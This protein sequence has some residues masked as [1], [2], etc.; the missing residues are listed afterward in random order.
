MDKSNVGKNQNMYLKEVAI[1]NQ[2][3]L[4]HTKSMRTNQKGFSAV[5]AIIILIVVGLLAFAGWYVWKKNN[6]DP[7]P[8]NESVASQNQK[9]NETRP[10]EKKVDP[11]A[12]WKS[13]ELV[14][15]K[16]TYKY[17]ADWNQDLKSY[18]NG[19][20]GSVKPGSEDLT[21]TGPNSSLLLE[22]RTG[23]DGVG[24]AVGGKVIESIPLQTMGSSL[25]LNFYTFE[26]DTDG[27]AYGA[28][29]DAL[30]TSADKLSGKNITNSRGVKAPIS[31]CI[32]YPF[33]KGDYVKKTVD[34]FKNDPSFADMKRILESF[35][36]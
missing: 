7:E 27:K 20:S 2:Q 4:V 22:F 14:Y 23:L 11:Y 3:H 36:Y 5:E 6:K 24:S 17:P 9:K 13:G 21:L 12:G 25:Y 26:G 8:K 16:L 30:A 1:S 28:C 34:E 33:I 10:E 15:E 31:A 32:R 19:P 18:P 29:L 35:T